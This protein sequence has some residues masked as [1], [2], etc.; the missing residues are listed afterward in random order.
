[1]IWPFEVRF[2]QLALGA[3]LV[4]AVVAPVVGAFLV[5]RRL[6]LFGD[7]IGHVAFAGVS[8]GLLTGTWPVLT[9]LVAAVAAALV[10]ERLRRNGTAGDVALALP[11]YV[12]LAGGVV[13]AS[14][15]G[16]LDGQLVSY[17]FGSILTVQSSEVLLAAIVGA[18]T[19]AVLA[20]VRRAMFSTVLDE[21]WSR[22][23]GLP[24]DALGS[25]LGVL[26]AVTVVMSMR[27]VGL[28]LVSALMV[29]PVAAAS[30]MVRSF[31]GT[32]VVAAGVGI[33][34]VLVGLVAARAFDLAPGGSIVLVTGAIYLLTSLRRSSG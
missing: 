18:A 24:T 3:G 27:V 34:S 33:V 1:M 15:A 11:F 4:V 26:A 5:Q 10:V 31:A 32:V 29:L 17:L 25:V 28:L 21:E 16:Q 19:L 14:K 7:G 20:V 8:V 6:A 13:V 12:G 30:R 9:A 22:I 23:A 2:M